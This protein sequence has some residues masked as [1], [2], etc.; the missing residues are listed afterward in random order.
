M[1]T[2]WRT[3]GIAVGVVAC[4]TLVA[5][6]AGA[7]QEGST[8]K[9][10]AAGGQVR[11]DLSAGDYTI[12]PGQDN[13]IVVRWDTRA[14]DSTTPVKVDIRVEGMAATITTSGPRNN[15]KVVIELPARE[16]LRVGISAGNL[17]IRG[18]TGSKD[19]ESWA[20]NI[21]IAVGKSS[22]YA[23]VDASVTAGDLVASA[24]NTTKGGLFRSFSW[25][26]PGRYTLRVKL[27]AGNVRLYE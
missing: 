19:V 1:R 22:D 10:F 26:G 20:G 14:S 12:E 3:A 27:T 2:A 16:D 4:L 23:T 6:T 25:K 11:M 21:D 24:F 15:F 17:K 5:R 7:Q 8:E 9:P 18:I 13:R